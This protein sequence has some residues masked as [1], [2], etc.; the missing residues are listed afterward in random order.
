[1]KI[2]TVQQ[3]PEGQ[4]VNDAVVNALNVYLNISDCIVNVCIEKPL[5]GQRRDAY[6]ADELFC[7]IGSALHPKVAVQIMCHFA[8]KAF[9]IE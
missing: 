9:R 3:L 4:H 1:M 8:L 7:G 6:V 2:A 5:Y